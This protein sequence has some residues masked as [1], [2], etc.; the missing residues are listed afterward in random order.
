VNPVVLF[1]IVGGIIVVALVM[2]SGGDKSEDGAE[3]GESGGEREPRASRM[4]EPSAVSVLDD[5]DDED[6]GG[7]VEAAAITSDGYAFVPRGTLGVEL[8]PPGEDDEEL[9]HRAESHGSD[10][11]K[12]AMATAPINPHTGKRLVAWKPGET[13]DVGDMI[14]ARIVRGAPDYDPWRLEALGRDYDYRLFAFETQE[15]AQI[16]L[17]LV[18]ERIVRAPRD[19]SGDEIPVGAEDFAVARRQFDETEEALAMESDE[20]LD[21]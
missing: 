6:E 19:K 1:L 11:L 20:E 3:P 12:H 9:R 16:A 14:A 5:E 18:Q 15:A 21:S 4:R 13:L 7:M 17:K 10:A 2:R 8:V